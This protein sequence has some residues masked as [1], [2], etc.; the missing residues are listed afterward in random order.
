MQED[1]LKYPIGKFQTKLDYTPEEIQSFINRIEAVPTY[2]KQE[3]QHLTDQQLD[4]PYREGGWT[5]RQVMHHVADSHMNAYIRMKWALTEAGP[6]I[7]AYEEKLWAGTPETK[8]APAL[9]WNLLIALHAKMVVL[10]KQIS[11]ADL[12]RTFTNPQSNKVIRIDQL[13]GMYAWHGDHHLAH[14]TSLKKR[15]DWK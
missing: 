13:L 4:T 12:E 7:K 3:L 11:L 9:S 6:I 8:A 5:L 14:I 2:Y 15:M 1:E 10:A